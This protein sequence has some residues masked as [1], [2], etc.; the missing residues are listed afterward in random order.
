VIGLRDYGRLRVYQFVAAID[1]FRALEDNRARENWEQTRVLASAVANFS[2][3]DKN[4]K[5]KFLQE[6]DK[7]LDGDGDQKSAQEKRDELLK[8]SD[9][10]HGDKLE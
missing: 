7:I 8:L 4:S 6:L 2:M 1:Q 10:L 9:E 5:K 3:A